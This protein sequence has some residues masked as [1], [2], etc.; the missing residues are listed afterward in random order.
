LGL[1]KYQLLL[2]IF[3]WTIGDLL[4]CEVN[5][6]PNSTHPY[7]GCDEHKHPGT[8]LNQTPQLIFHLVQH[9]ALLHFLFGHC[10]RFPP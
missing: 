5:N 8:A 9:G 2:Q 1:S 10:H 4:N 3:Q 6:R 7:C